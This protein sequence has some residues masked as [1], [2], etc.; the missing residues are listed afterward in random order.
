MG[1]GGGESFQNQ[2]STFH[3]LILSEM[4]LL[5]QVSVDKVEIKVGNPSAWWSRIA[6]GREGKRGGDVPRPGHREGCWR[7][8]GGPS[9][10]LR[11]DS[12]GQG[13]GCHLL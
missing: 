10:N 11:N 1:G 3:V 2:I 5:G 9:Y 12:Q 7:R 13:G 6:H 8:E 4:T